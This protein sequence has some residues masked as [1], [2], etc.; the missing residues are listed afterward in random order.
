[1]LAFLSPKQKKAMGLSVFG[2][3]VSFFAGGLS[4]GLSNREIW[5]L[6]FGALGWA[7][8]EIAAWL[9][10]DYYSHRRHRFVHPHT[11]FLSD[12]LNPAQGVLKLSWGLYLLAFLFPLLSALLLMEKGWVLMPLAFFGFFLGYYGWAEPFEWDRRLFGLGLRSMGRSFLPFLSGLCFAP[13]NVYRLP[14]MI[15]V[16]VVFFFNASEANASSTHVLPTYIISIARLPIYS[17]RNRA[18][19]RAFGKVNPF[20]SF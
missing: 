14:W 7:L 19:S 8:A 4:S 15:P 10:G 18:P 13:E 5:A 3:E 20:K 1:M 9:G 17:R 12:Q 6:F 16:F 2:I 11:P